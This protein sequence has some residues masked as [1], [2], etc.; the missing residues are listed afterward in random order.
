MVSCDRTQKNDHS[1]KQHV[2]NDSTYD[3][4]LIYEKQEIEEVL[5]LSAVYARQ[6]Q[7]LVIC[8][9]VQIDLKWKTV[10]I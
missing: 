8:I 4:I 10:D 2:D 3:H 9:K 7:L 1:T 6:I 5:R